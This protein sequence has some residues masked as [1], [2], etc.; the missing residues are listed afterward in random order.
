MGN[1]DIMKT[2]Q[3]PLNDVAGYFKR[4]K[5]A[6]VEQLRSA[7]GDPKERTIFRKLKLLDYLSSYSHRGMYYTLQSIA[8]F[9]AQGLWS[10]MRR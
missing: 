9:N 5:I 8:E 4:H 7:L 3:Y 10:H 2:E 1:I 6:T